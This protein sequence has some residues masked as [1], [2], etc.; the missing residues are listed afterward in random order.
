[1]EASR[2][3][4]ASLLGGL[5]LAAGL[6]ACASVPP[7]TAQLAVARSSLDQASAQPITDPVAATALSR[8]RDE[9]A[10]ANRA[11]DNKDYVVARRQAEL[12]DA[13]ARLALAAARAAGS[14]QAVTD[15]Q[16]SLDA[17][18]SEIDRGAA[19]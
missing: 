3:R 4:A 13:D 16:K 18:R 15:V 14:Q 2:V 17:L 12:A 7:P 6:G 8:A 1:M 11:L 5:V 19:R 9:I 10:A